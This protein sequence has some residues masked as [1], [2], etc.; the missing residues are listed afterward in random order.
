MPKHESG[1]FRWI[2]VCLTLAV[3]FTASGE[4]PG[5]TPDPAF[6]FTPPPCQGNVF[7]DVNCS[8]QFDAWIEQYSRDAITGGCGGGNYCPNNPVTRGQM[9]VF[10]EKAMRGSTNWPPQTV[11]VHAVLDADGTPNPA[12]SGQ[13]L[14]A[15]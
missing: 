13:A 9:A 1:R 11:L 10:V 3:P 12:A 4:A 15:A 5:A 7:L 2:L 14:L 8:G 6:I